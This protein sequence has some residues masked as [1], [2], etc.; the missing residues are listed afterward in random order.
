MNNS[1]ARIDI[2]EG[3]YI[4]WRY[5]TAWLDARP[6][7]LGRQSLQIHDPDQAIRKA[8]EII[9]KSNVKI[10]STLISPSPVAIPKAEAIIEQMPDPGFGEITLEMALTM[11]ISDYKRR[12]RISSYIRTIY[13]LRAFLR[14]VGKDRPVSSVTRKIMRLWFD[15]RVSEC[16]GATANSDLTRIHGFFAWM[17]AEEFVDRNPVINIKKVRVSTVAK[18]APTPEDVGALIQKARETK[19]PWLTDYVI[20]LAGTGARPQE[21]LRARICD[22]DEAKGLLR[23]MA[24]EGREIKTG[25]DRTIAVSTTVKEALARRKAAAPQGKPEAPLFPAPATYAKF[26]RY[27]WRQLGKDSMKPYD[28]R[29]YFCTMAPTWGWSL[30]RTA[31]Y[32]G[33][34]IQVL[35]RFYQDRR[36]M[37]LGAPPELLTI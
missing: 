5:K 18:G 4:F 32:V 9:S 20:A 12:N 21:I 28:L 23:I 15:R 30:E 24:F 16:S 7:G 27:I 3:A 10:A 29:H 1:K 33:N 36:A 17:V 22:F 26:T 34:S 6:L 31:A 14:D 25:K 8:V 35:E 13:P 2:I 11:Y 37:Q 19:H